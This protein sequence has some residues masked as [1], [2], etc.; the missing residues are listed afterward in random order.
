MAN[1]V[2][3]TKG[4]NEPDISQSSSFFRVDSNLL[5]VSHITGLLCRQVSQ[6]TV[7]LSFQKMEQS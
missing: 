5:T 6:H 2:T 4:H 1:I 3:T 7:A